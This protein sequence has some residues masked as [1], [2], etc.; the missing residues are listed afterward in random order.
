MTDAQ[1]AVVCALE[2][3][4]RALESRLPAGVDLVR[5]GSGPACREAVRELAERGV[6][7]IVLAG[8][9]G[10]LTDTDTCPAIARVLDESGRAWSVSGREGG[11]GVT[12]LGVD[13]VVDSPREKAR[14]AATTGAALVDTESQHFAQ[15]AEAAS[16]AWSIVRGVSDGPRESLPPG[17]QRW[18]TPGGR[19]DARRALLG[20]ARRPW[21]LPRVMALGT[22]S[23]HAMRAAGEQLGGEIERLRMYAAGDRAV[24]A[25][26]E[27]QVE[28]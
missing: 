27:A 13:R 8:V 21:V 14:L 2:F 15:A 9:C 6:R 26:A 23:R 16:V 1:A 18:V 5:T 22:R 11:D 7:V 20:M 17:V 28:L 4:R 3:E 24:A 19:T 25:T 10:G 12:L